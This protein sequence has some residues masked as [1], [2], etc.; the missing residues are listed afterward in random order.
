MFYQPDYCNHCG[1]KI[2]AAARPFWQN[3]RFCESCR[4]DFKF[5]EWSPRIAGLICVLAGLFGIGS[6][7]QKDEKPLQLNS[8]RIAE[9]APETP[10]KTKELTLPNAANT[11]VSANS[12]NQNPL[13]NGSGKTLAAQPPQKPENVTP[14]TAADAEPTYF[15]GAATKKGTPCSRRVKGGGR[16]WQHQGQPAILPAEKLRAEK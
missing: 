15:C 16:C 1:E 6:F 4:E 2:E 13:A 5:Q 7:L 9:A 10:R 12:V 8:R 3:S 11:Q 14:V